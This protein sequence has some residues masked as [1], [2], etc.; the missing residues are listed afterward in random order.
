MLVN[1][2]LIIINIV[3]MIFGYLAIKKKYDN[4]YLN[5]KILD[6]IKKELNDILKNL[7]SQTD[8]NIT[9]TQEVSA[10]LDKKIA[11]LQMYM[12]LVNKTTVAL[13]ENI[14]KYRI[15]MENSQNRMTHSIPDITTNIR[16]NPQTTAANTYSLQTVAQKTKEIKATEQ[17][18]QQIKSNHE[19]RLA[20]IKSELKEME[21]SAQVNYLLNL[22]WSQEMI[23]DFLSIPPGELEVL[24]EYEKAK[25]I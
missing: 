2:F 6:D 3:I 4:R 15:E 18:K 19:D 9:V 23:Q 16:Q 8:K 1:F 13:Q 21:L 12:A 22:N 25:T 7:N 11:E 5:S 14:V 24:L 17:Q 10:N 20:Q